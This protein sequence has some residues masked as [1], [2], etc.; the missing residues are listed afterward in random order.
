[1]ATNNI[2]VDRILCAVTFAP[3][4]RRVVAWAASLAGPYGGEVRLFHAVAASDERA[5]AELEDDSE[6]VLKKL[7]TLGEGLPGRPRISAVVT[8]GSAAAEILR[9]ARMV[10]ADVIAVGMRG[11]DGSVSPLVAR[12]AVNTP[13]PVLAVDETSARCPP[14]S[15]LPEQVVVAVNFLPPALAAADYAFAFGHAANAQ[16]TAVHVLPERWEGPRRR[17]ANVDETRRLVERH[18]QHLLHAMVSD[19]SGANGN[20]SESVISGQ[21]CAELVRIVTARDADLIVMG[22]DGNFRCGR[23]LGETAR[24]VM[25]CARKTVLLVP[26]RLSRVRETGRA[27]RGGRSY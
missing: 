17:D 14:R 20:R 13:C 25:Q 2:R 7:S 4:S 27:D 18:F 26:E 5:E 24:C 12:L 21:P 19:M 11:R 9:H 15:G 1:M 22:I 16:V 3:S 23:E 10:R 6:C 8:E